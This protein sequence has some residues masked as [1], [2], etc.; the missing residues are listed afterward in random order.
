MRRI[1]LFLLLSSTCYITGSSLLEA[2]LLRL[3]P[4]FCLYLPL[5]SMDS[6]LCRQRSLGFFESR[7]YLRGDSRYRS[8]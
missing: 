2:H 3:Q 1:H 8:L 6:L 5:L 7:K 4:N